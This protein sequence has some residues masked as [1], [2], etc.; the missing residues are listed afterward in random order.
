MAASPACHRPETEGRIGML[1]H[2]VPWDNR[3]G[4]NDFTFREL[5]L[6]CGVWTQNSWMFASLVSAN[7]GS[8]DGRKRQEEC[9]Q[10]SVIDD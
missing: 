9:C 7:S 2:G 3:C 4:R 5:A 8:T 6:S 10:I 1:K